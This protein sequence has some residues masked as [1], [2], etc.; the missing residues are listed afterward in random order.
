LKFFRKYAEKIQVL[1]KYHK[2][3]GYFTWRPVHICNNIS[4]NYSWKIEMFQTKFVENI[5][6]RIYCSITFFP[7]IV[8]FMS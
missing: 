5:K 7:K 6:T 8:L 3:D 4:R 1:L 2:N